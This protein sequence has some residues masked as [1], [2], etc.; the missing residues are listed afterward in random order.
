MTK[1]DEDITAS[2]DGSTNKEIDAL[3]DWE[4]KF[5]AYRVDDI[6]ETITDSP[7]SPT[8]VVVTSSTPQFSQSLPLLNHLLDDIKEPRS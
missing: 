1:K 8:T 6:S 4:K 5:E 3:A 7:L 2:L